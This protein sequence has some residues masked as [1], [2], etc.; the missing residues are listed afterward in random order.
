MEGNNPDNKDLKKYAQ[1]VQSEKLPPPRFDHIVKL[2]S[3]TSIAI[4]GGAITLDEFNNFI[5]SIGIIKCM[6]NGFNSKNMK[7]N[8]GF[9]LA[10]IGSL[11]LLPK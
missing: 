11:E 2:I 4:L 9:F 6:G 7:T 5:D 8:P 3:K 1:E 10:I